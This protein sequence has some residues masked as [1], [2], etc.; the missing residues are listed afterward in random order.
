M[1]TSSPFDEI[2]SD[3]EASF[4]QRSE[5]VAAGGWLVELL[6]P[7]ARV[8]DL[9]CGTGWPTAMQLAGSG[10]D[11]VGVDTA[12]AMLEIAGNRV[13]SAR[14]VHADMRELPEGLGRFDAA[15]AFF[16]LSMLPR[17][18][19]PAMFESIYRLLRPA[20]C[21]AISM[22]EGEMDFAPLQV[23]GMPINVSAYPLEET[24]RIASETGFSV[25]STEVVAA[26]AQTRAVIA[27]D[28][29]QYLRA[30]GGR[31]TRTGMPPVAPP[32]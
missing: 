6:G 11:V 17:A 23:L 2:G 27:A 7:R 22:I 3:Y 28:R 30:R 25:V 13:P 1:Q 31:G 19:I 15:V 4:T 21:L 32:T 18:D 8:L 12:G 5:Q 14:F 16:S 24:V 29:Y 9:G 26:E 10:F 20:G